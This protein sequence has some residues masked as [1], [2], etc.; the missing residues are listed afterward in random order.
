MDDKFKGIS[1]LKRNSQDNHGEL[2]LVLN[3][4]EDWQI[5]KV[6]CDDLIAEALR[7]SSDERMISAVE[8]RLKR[9]Q[10]LLKQELNRELTAEVQMGLFSEL[11]CL[12]D[13]IAPKAGIEQALNSWVGP[14]L[15][16]QDFLMEKSAVEVKSYR[17]SKG[18][19]VS[20]SSAHQLSTDKESLFL[21]SFGLTPA[22]SG[23]SIEDIAASVKDLLPDSSDEFLDLFENKLAKYGYIPEIIKE[24]L[25]K[26]ITDKTR[27]YSVT[28]EFPKIDSKDI[29]P[30]IISLKYTIDLSK[31]SEFEIDPAAI[32]F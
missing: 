15:D 18:A 7:S 31:C 8:A 4:K 1:I 29:Q 6:L 21:I 32:N 23:L 25:L 26:F 5:F 10:R 24:P 30:Q 13:I 22:D 9:W 20:I 28:G 14:D 19:A 12:R 11:L 17:T 3:N 16:R 27:A 2:F